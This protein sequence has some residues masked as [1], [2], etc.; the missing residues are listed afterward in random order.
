MRKKR[1]QS[2]PSLM[3][4]GG[5]RRF[6]PR[7]RNPDELPGILLLRMRAQYDFVLMRVWWS[8]SEWSIKLLFPFSICVWNWSALHA[9]SIDNWD[10]CMNAE[11]IWGLKNGG[12]EFNSSPV[13][14]KYVVVHYTYGSSPM[15]TPRLKLTLQ[16]R[17]FSEWRVSHHIHWI[18][19]RK[20][21]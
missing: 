16:R 10:D 1:R 20:I 6:S 12:Y 17:P 8:L 5:E 19:Q 21:W 11:C 18:T 9:F 14:R 2:C 13:I 15:G 4:Q 3:C 7:V